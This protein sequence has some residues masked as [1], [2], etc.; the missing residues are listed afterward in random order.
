MSI[1]GIPGIVKYAF[2]LTATPTNICNAFK[3]TGIWLYNSNVFTDED[4]APY[5]VT[6][7]PI[8][9]NQTLKD[10]QFTFPFKQPRK[11]S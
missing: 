9:N 10:R 2:P 4:F 5:F 11:T 6:D 7:R 3:K 8:L 1:Y